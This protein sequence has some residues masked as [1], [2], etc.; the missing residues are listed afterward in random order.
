MQFIAYMLHQGDQIRIPPLDTF[1]TLENS[2]S[3]H[4]CK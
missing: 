3:N 1:M 2:S 4:V